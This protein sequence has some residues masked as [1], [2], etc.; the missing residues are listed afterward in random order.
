MVP[1]TSVNK[2]G[3]RRQQCQV[4]LW[5]I[6]KEVKKSYQ[7][8]N[9]SECLFLCIHHGYSRAHVAGVSLPSGWKEM[10]IER[11]AKGAPFEKHEIVG[12]FLKYGLGDSA[13]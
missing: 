5:Y 9:R 3:M 8:H 2:A 7:Q 4:W 6:L 12:W 13:L 11:K 1:S 10:W